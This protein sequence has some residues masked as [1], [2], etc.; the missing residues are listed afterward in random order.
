MKT[1]VL[2]VRSLDD[3]MAD[4][5]TALKSS[6]PDEAARISFA[7]PEL[8][9]KVLTAERLEILKAMTGAGS[10]GIRELS[11]RV[12]RDVKAV[13]DDVMALVKAGLID[14]VE[15]GKVLFPYDRV[16]VRFD[17]STAA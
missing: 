8:L 10:L 12:G 16:E 1:V 3:S 17:L 15:G 5:A 14:R 13:H 6:A 7:T 11:R 9:W 4:I 2:E